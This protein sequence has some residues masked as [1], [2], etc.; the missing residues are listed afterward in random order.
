MIGN[1]CF[2]FQSCINDELKYIQ[3]TPGSDVDVFLSSQLGYVVEINDIQ[4]FPDINYKL[5]DACKAYYYCPECFDSNPILYDAFARNLNATGS[6]TCP[7]PPTAYILV[8]CRYI[9]DVPADP[10]D[11]R[12]SASTM[13]VTSSGLLVYSEMVVTLE[14]Y[15]GNCYTV[16]G[17]YTER[18]GCPCEYVTVLNAS[19]DCACCL[20]GD[21]VPP[22]P[23]V[24][25]KPVNQFYH[26]T[27]TQCEIKDNTTFANNYY[28]LFTGIRYGIQNCCPGIDFE[29]VWIKKELSDY[30]RINP[31]V[32]CA[33]PIVEVCPDPCPAPEP[34]GCFAAE[35]VNASGTF[36]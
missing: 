24:I 34:S 18:T 14:E 11:V 9:G 12:P 15:P 20:G 30:A 21:P 22:L 36:S 32:T 8:N 26:I 4:N 6:Q 25:P 3:V 31:P 10:E 5:I 27:D 29:K 17:P 33:P 1:K 19:G 28:K 7:V 13:L 16:H 35:D 23:R 2:T